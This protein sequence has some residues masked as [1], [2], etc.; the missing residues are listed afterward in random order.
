MA[1][2]TG[3]YRARGIRFGRSD[4]QISSTRGGAR[5]ALDRIRSDIPR[6]VLFVLTKKVERLWDSERSLNHWSIGRADER[7]RVNYYVRGAAIFAGDSAYRMVSL[8]F[9]GLLV[10]QVR[11]PTVAVV[12]GG[13]VL[14]YSLP[15][16]F[17]EVQSRYHVPMIPF[18]IIGAAVFLD[19]IAPGFL[20]NGHTRFPVLHGRRNHPNAISS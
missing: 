2:T 15:H 12:L 8:L 11:R 18:M 20:L 14:L 19:R 7:D 3:G 1:G 6:F 9:L 5:T 13:V 16:V 10:L 4:R 17:I